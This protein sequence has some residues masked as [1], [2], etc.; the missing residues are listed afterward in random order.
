LAD[1]QIGFQRANGKQPVAVSD[2]ETGMSVSFRE[3]QLSSIEPL[4]TA[5]P[6]TQPIA[7]QV[8]W[9]ANVR[10]ADFGANRSEGPLSAR[11]A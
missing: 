7:P 6:T 8:H 4:L 9:A 10:V 11:P 5:A 1:P 2:A 3:A